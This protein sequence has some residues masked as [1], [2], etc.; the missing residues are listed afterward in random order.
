V[1]LRR[2]RLRLAAP[3]VVDDQVTR[4]TWWRAPGHHQ[5]RCGSLPEPELLADE[6]DLLEA[7]LDLNILMD[8]QVLG[9]P[10]RDYTRANTP[11]AQRSQVLVA[12]HL[13]GRLRLVVTNGV[14]RELARR[15]QD[16]RDRVEQAANHYTRRTAG[17]GEAEEVFAQLVRASAGAGQALSP[18][19]E[20][21]L[22]QIAEAVASS[23]GVLLIWD[24]GLRRRFETLQRTVPALASFHVLDPDNLVTHLDEVARVAS[25]ARTDRRCSWGLTALAD[26]LHDQCW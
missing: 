1:T 19:D 24:D 5:R 20:G 16:Q 4:P 13:E 11:G 14:E 6:P 21:D 10:A 26:H 23:V 22:W 25:S 15:P 9:R 18:Q 8:L 12:D 7:A 3:D 2:A 17:V